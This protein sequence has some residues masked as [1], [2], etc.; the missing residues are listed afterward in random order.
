MY[1]ITT[2]IAKG[3][4]NKNQ[5]MNCHETLEHAL[6]LLDNYLMKVHYQNF[7]VR[8]CAYVKLKKNYIQA[9][10]ANN[11]LENYYDQPQRLST[12][13]VKEYLNNKI[14]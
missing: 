10:Q 14:V 4:C 6:I 12:Y 1:L 5:E 2:L 3:K 8:E 7:N 11:T 9:F 13:Q